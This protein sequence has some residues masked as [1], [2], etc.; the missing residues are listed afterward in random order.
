MWVKKNF[1]DYSGVSPRLP[2]ILSPQTNHLLLSFQSLYTSQYTN[3]YIINW[4][5][6]ILSAVIHDSSISSLNQFSFEIIP[7]NFFHSQ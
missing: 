1:K 7:R 4:K 2:C 5:E 6:N 3:T